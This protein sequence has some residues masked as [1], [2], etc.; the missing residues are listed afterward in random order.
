MPSTKNSRRWARLWELERTNPDALTAAQ[1][2]QLARRREY[3]E[4]KR[5]AV[6]AF[7]APKADCRV[8][9]KR[10]PSKMFAYHKSCW[11]DLPD[12]ACGNG[13]RDFNPDIGTNTPSCFSCYSQAWS[14][15]DVPG[16]D[17][18][19]MRR[20]DDRA[21]YVVRRGDRFFAMARGADGLAQLGASAD[22]GLAM[23]RANHELEAA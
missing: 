19:W 1:R 4:R 2:Q 16:A 6:A 17:A 10:L 13:K 18:A 23:I 11:A 8:C 5:A 15:A 14:S 22:M 7:R 21:G 3:D 12:C 9:G 20:L